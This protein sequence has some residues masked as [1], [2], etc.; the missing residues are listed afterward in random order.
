MLDICRK[1]VV[2][3]KT[4]QQLAFYIYILQNMAQTVSVSACLKTVFFRLQNTVFLSVYKNKYTNRLANYC[5][6]FLFF[7]PRSW[8]CLY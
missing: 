8:E 5:S 6:V 2:L 4:Q 7:F 3:S 1:S